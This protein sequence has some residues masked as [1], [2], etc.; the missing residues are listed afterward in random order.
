MDSEANV[1]RKKKTKKKQG[2]WKRTGRCSNTKQTELEIKQA[3]S[4]TESN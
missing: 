2:K 1:W 4:G 3:H